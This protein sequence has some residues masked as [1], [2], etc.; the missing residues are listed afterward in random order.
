M[1]WPEAAEHKAINADVDVLTGAMAHEL[2][3]RY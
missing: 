3:R 1:H 2:L